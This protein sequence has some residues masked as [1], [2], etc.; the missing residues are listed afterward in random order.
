[1]ADIL[2]VGV[3]TSQHSVQVLVRVGVG[4]GP[5]GGSLHE[6]GI[7]IPSSL[8]QQPGTPIVDPVAHQVAYQALW[9]FQHRTIRV[10]EPRADHCAVRVHALTHVT[11]GVGQVV[12]PV[13]GARLSQTVGAVVSD[14]GDCGTNNG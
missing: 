9:P 4:V 5:D 14:H 11:C 12:Q 10:K 1:G 2:G 7:E 8:V 13:V 3:A 6:V